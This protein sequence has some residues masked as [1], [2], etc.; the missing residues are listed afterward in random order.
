MWALQAAMRTH[1]RS[2]ACLAIALGAIPAGIDLEVGQIDSCHCELHGFR[3]D[4]LI[5]RL[6]D[7]FAAKRRRPTGDDFEGSGMQ[8]GPC[9]AI[10]RVIL[11]G[12]LE[13]SRE[14]EPARTGA[15]LQGSIVACP[16]RRAAVPSHRHASR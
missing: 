1:Y 11:R 12:A 8:P 15:I 7:I 4:L 3:T 2:R 14:T 9:I 6:A 13:P 16:A 10:G 5:E